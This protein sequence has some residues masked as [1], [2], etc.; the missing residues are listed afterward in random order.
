MTKSNSKLIQ[1]WSAVDVYR[2]NLE[3]IIGHHASGSSFRHAGPR[4]MQ[5]ERTSPPPDHPPLQ[6]GNG[7][8]PGKSGLSV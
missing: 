1:L 6:W 7:R 3:N 8:Q 4:A 5:Q 2:D